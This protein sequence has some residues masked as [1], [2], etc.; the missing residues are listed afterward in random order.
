[1]YTEYYL[2]IFCVSLQ[3]V[4]CNISTCIVSSDTYILNLGYLSAQRLYV[5][6]QGCQDPWLFLEAKGAP[7]VKR[8]GKH[9]YR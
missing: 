9:C 6:Q 2:V 4:S 5:R 1:M 8:F 7:R 3:K